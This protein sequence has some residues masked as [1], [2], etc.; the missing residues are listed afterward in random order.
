MRQLHKVTLALVA[1]A[2]AASAAGASVP[3]AG[4]QV[5]VSPGQALLRGTGMQ[6]S[7]LVVGVDGRIP[8]DVKTTSPPIRLACNS[9]GNC[10][11]DESPC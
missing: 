1:A 4:Q 2:G 9:S 6:P 7:D 8:V 10:R 3:S 5:S 11:A